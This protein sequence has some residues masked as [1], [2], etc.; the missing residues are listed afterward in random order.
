MLLDVV[1][2]PRWTI[3]HLASPLCQLETETVTAWAPVCAS[4]V[5]AKVAV[6]V[7]QPAVIQP[8]GHVVGK[9]PAL[10]AGQSVSTDGL[11]TR[12]DAGSAVG[13][14]ATSPPVASARMVRVVQNPLA[15]IQSTMGWSALYSAVPVVS[16]KARIAG[17]DGVDCCI[18]G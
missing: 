12:P 7:P 16:W 10:P 2:E 5:V 15:F 1:P 18:P 13:G 8:A 14:R 4:V 11:T 9:L 6:R 3:T 17:C